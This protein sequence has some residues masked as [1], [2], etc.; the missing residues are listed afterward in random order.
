MK[1]LIKVLVSI[2]LVLTALFNDAQHLSFAQKKTIYVVPETAKIFYNGAEVGNGSYEVKFNRNEDFVMLKFEAP[3]YI[4]KTVR[5]FKNN[6]KKTIYYELFQDEAEMN[7]I[8]AADGFDVANKYFSITAKNSMT[9]DEAWK[10]LMNIAV[11]N[12]ENIEVRDKSAGWIRTGW[13][14][15]TF[16]YQTVRTRMEIQAQFTG[17]N[18][19]SYRILI[20]SEK[21]DN[22]CGLQDNCFVRYGR[23]LKKYEGLISS[24]Q[25]TLGSN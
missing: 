5:L 13:S 15:T 22:D 16:A 20:T 25:T 8:G 7:S 17:D 18:E 11:T 4:P 6:P 14:R 2:S 3:G 1:L 21:A 23:L 10:R 12:F 19:L 9:E 24:L